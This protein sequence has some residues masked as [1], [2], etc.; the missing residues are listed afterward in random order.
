MFHFERTG[1]EAGR[2]AAKGVGEN[3]ASSAIADKNRADPREE[4]KLCQ[5]M[6]RAS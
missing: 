6:S 5:T 1:S 2:F 4:V 3:V